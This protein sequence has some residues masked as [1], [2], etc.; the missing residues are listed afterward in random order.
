MS[1]NDVNEVSDSVL[2]THYQDAPYFKPEW[3]KENTLVYHVI[4]EADN[5]H[6]TNGTS[7]MRSEIML[8]TQKFLVQTDMFHYN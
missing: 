2:F 3:S 8:Y 1:N 6:P 5:L 7:Y 4:A